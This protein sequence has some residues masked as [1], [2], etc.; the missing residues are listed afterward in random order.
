[1]NRIKSMTRERIVEL[2]GRFPSARIAVVG[3]FFLDKYLEVDPSITDTSVES[4]KMAHQ[5]VSIRHSPGAAGTVVCNLVALGCGTIYAVGIIG[6]DGEGYE[7]R[8]DLKRLRC[9]IPHLL[10]SPDRSTPTYL[11]PVDIDKH[12][13]EGEYER[14]DTKNRTPTSDELSSH[15][16]QSLSILL[17]EL[18]AVIIADQVEDDECGVITSMV[19]ESIT[20][21]AR[22]HPDVIFFAD[23]RRRIK[24]FRNVIVK[25]NQ[26]EAVGNPNPLPGQSIE[27]DRIWKILPDLR[28]SIGAP[29]IITCGDRGVVV[30]DPEPTLIPSVQNNGPTDS[31]GAGDSFTAGSVLALASNSN[32]AESALIGNLVASITVQQL[33]TTGTARPDQLIERLDIWHNQHE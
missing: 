29:V 3:D 28:S 9:L 19:R 27:P 16:I 13:L 12:G 20:D 8:D 1:M 21:L 6:N 4:G 22:R 2:V 18:D 25:P 14:Y 24:M 23:S 15:I 7:L 26:F 5:V 17:P 30:S 32:L 11:K 10:V 33:N 31:T